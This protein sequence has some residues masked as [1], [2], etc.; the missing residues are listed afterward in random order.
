MICK[1]KA[2]EKQPSTV[3]IVYTDLHTYKD[4]QKSNPGPCTQSPGNSP[5]RSKET[6][7][8]SGL[9]GHP[10]AQHHPARRVQPR[11]QAAQ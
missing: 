11:V 6:G 7:P 2:C 9:P 4:N 10:L 1:P 8:A 5:Q 3:Y